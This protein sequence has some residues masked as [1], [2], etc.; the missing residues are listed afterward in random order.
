MSIDTVKGDFYPADYVTVH[1]D[2]LEKL[3]W[4]SAQ[5]YHSSK[6]ATD[7]MDIMEVHRQLESET[8]KSI[9]LER[10]LNAA[11]AQLAAAE[12][13][14]GVQV[15]RAESAEARL[16]ECERDAPTHWAIIFDDYDRRPEIFGG[17][18]AE[19][20]ARHRYKAI[21]YNWNAHLFARVESNSRDFEQRAARE[22]KP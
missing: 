20:A 21:S 15:Q 6:D 10:E 17:D 7:S 14:I 5:P 19:A 11:R 3:I 8:V 9:N 4:L 18:G 16:R 12:Q 13:L 1:K 2:Y 22:V